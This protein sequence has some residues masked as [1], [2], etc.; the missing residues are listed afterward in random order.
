MNNPLATFIDDVL[1]DKYGSDVPADEHEEMKKELTDKLN[2]W[3]TLKV[4]TELA[5]TSPETLQDFQTMVREKNPTQA[6][7]QEYVAGKIPESSA[8][9]TRILLEFRNTYLGASS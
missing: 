2:Q 1:K 3:I 4:M 5:K 6:E 9:L 7:V 8:F